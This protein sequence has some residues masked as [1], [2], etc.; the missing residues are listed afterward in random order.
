LILLFS[1]YISV[2][3]NTSNSVQFKI[4]LGVIKMLICPRRI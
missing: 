4:F 1:L 3:R 2:T